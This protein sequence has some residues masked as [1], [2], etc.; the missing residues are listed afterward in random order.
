MDLIYYNSGLTLSDLILICWSTGGAF[1][2][3]AREMEKCLNSKVV[4]FEIPP[5]TYQKLMGKHGFRIAKNMKNRYTER[6]F[7]GDHQKRLHFEFVYF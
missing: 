6:R 2:K 7:L 3:W 4:F 5:K 1:N